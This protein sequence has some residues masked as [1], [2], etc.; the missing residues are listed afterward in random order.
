MVSVTFPSRPQ[1]APLAE[2]PARAAPEPEPRG[3]REVFDLQPPDRSASAGP[4]PEVAPSPGRT[5]DPA[6][7]SPDTTEKR[8]AGER[9]AESPETAV[10]A[11]G[12]VAQPTEPPTDQVMTREALP[13]RAGEPTVIDTAGFLD[14]LAPGVPVLQA[15][16]M[17]TAAAG[18]EARAT[19]LAEP[20]SGP[21]GAPL[22]VPPPLVVPPPHAASPVEAAVEARPVGPAPADLLPPDQSSLTAA[23]PGNTAT[24]EPG[25]F[26]LAEPA[27]TSERKPAPATGVPP[28]WAAR[29]AADPDATA[30]D[31]RGQAQR[32][33]SAGN[34]AA[35]RPVAEPMMEHAAAEPEAET[36]ISFGG[37]E[38]PAAREPKQGP[39]PLQALVGGPSPAVPALTSL[40]APIPTVLPPQ[41]PAQI[42]AALA[43]RP[44]RPLELRLAPVELGGLTVNLRQD[45]DI[46]RVVVQADRPETLDLLRRNGEV[47]LEELRLAGFSGAALSFGDGGGTQDRQSQA[48]PRAAPAI[49]TPPPSVAATAPTSGPVLAAQGLDLRL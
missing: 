37:D 30:T 35:P 46:L 43:A 4:S 25:L 45:G 38:T 21:T 7:A 48:L 18:P 3:F 13:E 26:I 40:Q 27:V 23:A 2:A 44:E 5:G 11:G 1:A 33:R 31:D 29:E 20:V 39:A 34:P 9:D 22:F 36:A 47:L 8:L 41:V 19:S 49:D 42:A 15:L 24:E 10:I 28:F 16:M 32:D 6:E 14:P 12:P 17:L